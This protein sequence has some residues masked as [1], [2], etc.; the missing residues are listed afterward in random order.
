MGKY[1][2]VYTK[3]DYSS[4]IIMHAFMNMQVSIPL[5]VIVYQK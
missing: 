2:I 3:V 4:P 5:P 1:F